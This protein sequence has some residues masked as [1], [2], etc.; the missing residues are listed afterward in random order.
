MMSLWSGLKVEGRF[1][2]SVSMKLL[3]VIVPYD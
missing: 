1:S 3:T 2:L